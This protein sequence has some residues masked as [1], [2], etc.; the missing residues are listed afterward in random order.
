MLLIGMFFLHKKC[1]LV[2][3]SER[4]SVLDHGH[5]FS[6][7]TQKVVVLNGGIELRQGMSKGIRLVD[8]GKSVKA[9][10]EVDCKFI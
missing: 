9:A 8:D 2:Y 6:T 4:Y 3:F 1:K 10:F 5:L 7:D